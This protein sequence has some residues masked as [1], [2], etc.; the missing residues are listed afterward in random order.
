MFQPLRNRLTSELSGQNR[1]TLPI[2]TPQRLGA[3]DQKGPVCLPFS[4]ARLF[5][6]IAA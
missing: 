6:S 1:H 4:D 2:A 5:L 3:V